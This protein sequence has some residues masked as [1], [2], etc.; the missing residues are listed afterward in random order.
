MSSA[1]FMEKLLEGIE[2]EWKALGDIAEIYGGLTGKSKTDFENGNAKYVPYKNIFGNIEV[3]FNCLDSVKVADAENQNAQL[4]THGVSEFRL[5]WI[6]S[7]TQ[8]GITT[9]P[10]ILYS[11]KWQCIALGKNAAAWL[12]NN[13]HYYTEFEHPQFH[14]RFKGRKDYPLIDFLKVIT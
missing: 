3:N 4:V 1:K 11:R 8:K 2:M 7:A 9:D 6:N 10:N 14:R 13:G 12:T 5:F